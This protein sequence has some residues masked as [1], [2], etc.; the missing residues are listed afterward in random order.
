M[1]IESKNQIYVTYKQRDAL[2]FDKSK[3]KVNPK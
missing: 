2:D 3:I 1:V